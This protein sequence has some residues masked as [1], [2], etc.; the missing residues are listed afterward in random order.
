[1]ITLV[2]VTSISIYYITVLS[3]QWLEYLS[4]NLLTSV[5]IIIQYCCLY[6][7]YYAVN[8]QGLFTTHCKF[9]P[10]NNIC[11]NPATS[12]PW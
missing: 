2:V 5:M 7:L 11:P 6:S 10:L 3:F 12:I 4:S 9:V 8:L 1:M